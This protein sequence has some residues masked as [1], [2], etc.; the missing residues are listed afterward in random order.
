MATVYLAHDIK[1]DRTVAIKIL[2]EE[3]SASLGGDRFLREI[4]IAAQLPHPNILPLLDSGAED[5]ILFYVM[6]Y[7]SG[8]S[9]R[10]RI[11]REGAL[12]VHDAVRLI[13][14]V[15]DALAHA[16]ELGVV[17]RDIKPDNVMLSGRH[18]LVADFGVAKAVSDA[19]GGHMVTTVGT[20][21]GTP[22][23]MSP[24]Q[25]VADP[26]VDHR[27]DIYAVGAVVYELL[28]GQPPFV[29]GSPQQVLAAHVTQAPEAPSMHR[30]GIAPALDAIILRCLA[31]QAGDRF[32]T[33]AEL[34]AALEPWAT[35]SGGITPAE[36]ART[37]ASVAASSGK[38][39]RFA[40]ALSAVSVTAIATYVLLNRPP[41]TAALQQG[42]QLT[43]SAGVQEM[44]RI[45][46][47]GK[48]VR[49]PRTAATSGVSRCRTWARCR[50]VRPS[51]SRAKRKR[52]SAGINRC[53]CRA[54]W[55]PMSAILS[56]RRMVRGSR[57]RYS[58]LVVPTARSRWRWQR[59]ARAC[60]RA[61]SPV[62]S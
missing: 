30:A 54:A 10:E 35:A 39:T 13:I 21:I 46:S 36:T 42:T 49:R 56:G 11:I 31:K 32:Q 20:A 51:W 14:E 16:H 62:V 27:A 22:T 47:D 53:R 52:S 33:A 48:A 58:S 40:V 57:G 5:G 60:H 2:R 55:A 7:V 29:G 9:L 41:A 44:P 8:Q 18:A 19:T 25:A 3:L 17:H 34:H 45:S 6:P 38:G 26:H 28:T 50:A 37:T 59:G 12:P 4:R 15:V 23:Y 1:H 24:E 61:T 43:R